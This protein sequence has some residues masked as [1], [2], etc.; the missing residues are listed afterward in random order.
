[1]PCVGP[2][3]ASPSTMSNFF[4]S[5]NFSFF[6]SFY[7]YLVL[8]SRDAEPNRTSHTDTFAACKQDVQ[9]SPCLFV[10][11]LYSEPSPARP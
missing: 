5:F 3:K 7:T 1:M 8:N 2:T 10:S 9:E 11:C 6:L 4:L